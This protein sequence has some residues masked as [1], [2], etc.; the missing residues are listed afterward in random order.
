MKGNTGPAAFFNLIATVVERFGWPGFLLAFSL[1]SVQTYA[2]N[3]QKTRIIEMYVLG[4]GVG[5]VWPEMKWPMRSLG[6]RSEPLG[7]HLNM[8]RVRE[9][10]EAR[11]C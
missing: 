1:Y 8:V 9:R 10:I 2:T 7:K 6:F 5:G 4:Q 11:K 3:E